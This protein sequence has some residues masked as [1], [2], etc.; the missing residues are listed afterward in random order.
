[1]AAQRRRPRNAL[2]LLLLLP[3]L[4][5]YRKEVDSVK[6]PDG[7]WIDT[8]GYGHHAQSGTVLAAF[9]TDFLTE[10]EAGT[11]LTNESAKSTLRNFYHRHGYTKVIVIESEWPGSFI[12]KGI[13]P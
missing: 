8:I 10:H 13:A 11:A 9:R 2:P 12:V 6:H 4:L 3:V 5:I 1:M 7:S